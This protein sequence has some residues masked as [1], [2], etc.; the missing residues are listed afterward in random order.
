[1]RR[2]RPRALA[3][4][5]L[6]LLT[7]VASSACRGEGREKIRPVDETR[8]S[9]PPC[10]TTCGGKC[11]D[12]RRDAANC[13]RC[14]ASC[15]A[16]GQCLL[17]LCARSIG[18]ADTL[19]R[20]DAQADADA[21]AAATA[22]AA[23]EA[24]EAAG[25]A[26]AVGAGSAV[27][28]ASAATAASR[29]RPSTLAFVCDREHAAPSLWGSDLYTA[30]SSLCGAAAH[31][32]AISTKGG[33]FVVERRPGAATYDGSARFGVTSMPWGAFDE[34]FVVVAESCVPAAMRCGAQ[35]VDVTGDRRHCGACGHSCPAG[36]ACLAG[37][38]VEGEAAGKDTSAS[39]KGCSPGVEYTFQCPAYATSGAT[40]WGTELYTNDSSICVAAVHAGKIPAS[41]GRVTI[42]M[43]AGAARYV[44]STR[45][46]VTSEGWGSWPCS[47]EVATAKAAP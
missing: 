16:T 5:L 33:A 45:N 9:K 32:G 14:G 35:C 44:G 6:A 47:F 30:D 42:T 27:V 31:A 23:A 4:A 7:Q 1:M 24:V 29:T 22:A 19:R 37:G 34:S 8:T 38:C 26:D 39:A 13:G 20:V 28:D 25:A 46:G 3:I 10:P 17:G 18:W 12:L 15:G 40:V 43:R 11:V 2:V 36:Q 41:G 21:A